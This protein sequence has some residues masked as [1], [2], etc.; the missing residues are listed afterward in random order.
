MDRIEAE[1]EDE[2]RRG[3]MRDRS[4]R[5]FL[6]I[7]LTAKVIHFVVQVKE[8]VERTRY[9]AAQEVSRWDNKGKNEG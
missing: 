5:S 1:A 3:E 9:L 2:V 6:S 4:W 7:N 8:L